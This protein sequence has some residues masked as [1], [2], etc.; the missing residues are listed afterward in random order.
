MAVEAFYILLSIKMKN[1]W[2]SALVLGFFMI[3]NGCANL[4]K[5][6][7]QCDLKWE[8]KKA[9]IQSR[10]LAERYRELGSTCNPNQVQL[11][12]VKSFSLT[13]IDGRTY[14]FGYVEFE[15]DSLLTTKLSKAGFI[16]KRR[17]MD[18][19]YAIL[20]LDRLLWLDS[21]KEINKHCIEPPGTLMGF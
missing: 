5:G 9:C 10:R 11:D 17:V 2:F 20:P 15:E 12:S 7:S 21:L 19:Q 13:K 18:Y 6:A 1:I 8:F 4:K 16:L 14:G 3:F